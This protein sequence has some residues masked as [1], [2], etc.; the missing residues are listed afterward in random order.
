MKNVAKNAD[1]ISNVVKSFD[2]LVDAWKVCSTT[3]S[4]EKTNRARINKDRDVQVKAIEENSAILKLYLTRIF[5]ERAHVIDGMF[6]QLDKG[7]SC[8][9]MD[10]ASQ[11][12]N[13]IISVTKSS[14]L[15]GARELIADLRNPNVAQIE[16]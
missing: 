9:N 5:E 10:L 13:A 14:P 1:A 8:G 3:A 15:E 2:N 6:D 12:I 4:V 7:L 11:A 16:I